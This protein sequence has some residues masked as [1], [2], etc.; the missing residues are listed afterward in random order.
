MTANRTFMAT[1]ASYVPKWYVIDATDIPL[2]RLASRISLI[3]T[4]KSKPSYTPHVDTGDF[5]IVINADKVGF[6]GRRKLAET[7][8]YRHSGHPGGF[9]ETTYA[10]MM[11]KDSTRLVERIVRGMLPKS[12]LHFERKLK[13]YAG[14]DHPHAAQQPVQITL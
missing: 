2:G 13:V 7:K 10:E 14:A 1:K 8:V 11:Q 3:L 4:G 6:T 9:K 12:R 5:V